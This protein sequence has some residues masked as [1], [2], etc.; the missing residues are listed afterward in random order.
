MAGARLQIESTSPLVAQA[1]RRAAAQLDDP[2]P[3]YRDL[4]E[5]LLPL[6]KRRFATQ[7]G[8]DGRA[9]KRLSPRYQKR[10]PYNKD[11]V[12]TLRGFLGRQLAYQ[13]SAEGLLLGSNRK[14]AAIH[15]FGGEISIAARSQKAKFR[16]KANGARMSQADRGERFRN[17]GKLNV[18]AKRSSKRAETRNVTIGAYKIRMPARP[19]L[20]VSTRDRQLIAEVTAAWIGRGI[21][22]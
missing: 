9:W 2:T 6:T 13:A 14:Y 1:L 12:L 22:R 17:A 20:G 10:K 16:I 19:F 4:G 7:T 15:Q 3:L 8:P 5:G 11:K 18:F 21:P